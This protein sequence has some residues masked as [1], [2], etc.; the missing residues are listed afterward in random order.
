VTAAEGEQYGRAYGVPY[1]DGHPLPLGPAR[2]LVGEQSNTSIIVGATAG[3]GRE[4]DEDAPPPIIVKIFRVLQGGLNP[5]VSIQTVLAASGCERVPHPIGAWEA[6]WT[7]PRGETL[8]GHLG[9][10]SEF[11][12]GAQDAWRIA[13]HAVEEG[14]SFEE[15]AYGLG[16]A[17]AEVH[18]AL[19]HA[20]PTIPVDGERLVTFAAALSARVGWALSASDGVLEPYRSGAA[21]AAAGVGRL[22]SAPPLQHIHGDLHLGQVLNSPSRGWL[23][24]DFEGEP[25]RPLAERNAPDLALRDV[26]GL[27]R[28]FDYAARH[29]TA[30]LDVDDDRVAA[31][32]RWAE[33]AST[34]FLDGYAKGAGHDPR[35]TRSSTRCATGP[36]GFGC[37][38]APSVACWRDH[39]QQDPRNRFTMV[40][41]TR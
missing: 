10:A 3:D 19:A 13:C 39:P 1:G 16:V 6:T 28:S 2:V 15:E 18:S 11:F 31:A 22:R 5:D 40:R 25:L 38:W 17:T 37:R 7:G 24:L 32:Q 4:R 33:E 12:E 23:L 29:T 14:R 27:L 35:S 41:S 21:E 34:A 9:Y 30:D 26:A 8:T 20:L 36:T